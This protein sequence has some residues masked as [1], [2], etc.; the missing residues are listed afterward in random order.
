MYMNGLGPMTGRHR[1][2]MRMHHRPMG[3]FPLGGLFILPALV[4]GGWI[5]VAILAG[6]LSLAGSI[7]GGVFAGLGAMTEGVF[8]GSGLVIGIVI[9]LAAYYC[10]RNRNVKKEES[11]GTVDGGEA[12]TEII[13]PAAGT[14]R[15]DC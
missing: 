14:Y 3:F 6:V 4:F 7:V 10:F 11:T 5:A 12:D 2:P 15:A 9:G 13:E 1:G 8:S